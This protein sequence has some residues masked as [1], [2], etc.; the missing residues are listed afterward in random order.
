MHFFFGY[1]LNKTL[2]LY[3]FIF[4]KR[5]R[6]YFQYLCKWGELS[7]GTTKL[8][9]EHETPSIETMQMVAAISLFMLFLFAIY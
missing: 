3:L 5:F 4:M 2:V 8:T 1:V 7:S 9:A 6:W